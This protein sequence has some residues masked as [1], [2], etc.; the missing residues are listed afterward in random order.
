MERTETVPSAAAA[1]ATWLAIGLLGALILVGGVALFPISASTAVQN[2]EFTNLR[3]PLLALALAVGLCGETI[4]VATAIL[5][6]YIRQDRIFGHAAARMV[7]LLILTVVLATILTASTLAF[8]PGPPALAIVIVGSV[9][10]GITL[11][12]VL[13]VLRSLLQRTALMR[14]ELDEVV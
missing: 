5:V 6:G 4:L 1:T 12:L 3:A 13:I 9:L 14:S 2:P 8:I 11:T 10:V 7:N